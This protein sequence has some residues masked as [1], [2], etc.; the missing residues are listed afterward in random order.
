MRAHSATIRTSM[1][2]SLSRR[3]AR[4]R[5]PERFAGPGSGAA[6]MAAGFGT[7]VASGVGAGAATGSGGSAR[8]GGVAGAGPIADSTLRIA[9]STMST[10]RSNVFP[11]VSMI[12]ASSAAR[13]GA[14]ARLRSWASRSRSWARTASASSPAG[15]RPRSSMRRAARS[16]TEASRNSLRSASGS[17]TV[18]M[19]RPGDDDPAALRERALAREEGGAHLGLA[20]DRRH[21][22]IDLGSA[23]G[24]GRVGAVEED[25]RQAPRAVVPER[26]PVGERDEAG[27]VVGRDPLAQG[28][29]REGAVQQPRVH[30]PQPE[31]AG[32]G[33]ADAALAAG[34]RS[35]ERHDDPPLDGGLRGAGSRSGG[36]GGRG[37]GPRIP[38][39]SGADR[40]SRDRWR[41]AAAPR[42]R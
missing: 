37:H 17:T 38:G 25:R 27:R 33:G 3:M 6:A 11:S 21:G 12:T 14:T 13:S 1:V 39:R 26:D 19:S 35:V 30:E 18:P 5:L 36:L 34:R 9:P 31:P 41:R 40:V 28:G 42:R 7:V 20:R 8:A 23:R 4:S 10:V 29:R 16:S 32:R 15:S 2:W 22:G 24:R